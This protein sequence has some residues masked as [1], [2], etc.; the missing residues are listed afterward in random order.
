MKILLAIMM[1]II[2]FTI[3]CEKSLD[4]L[5]SSKNKT[6]ERTNERTECNSCNILFIGSSYLNYF[7]HD[8]IDIFERMTVL[9]G[10]NIYLGRKDASGWSLKKHVENQQTIELVNERN[11]D[12]VILQSGALYLSKEKWHDYI[13]P[14]IKEFRKVI[15]NNYKK[16]CVVYMLPWAY[17]DGLTW[18]EGEGDT[19]EEMQINLYNETTKLVKDIDIATAPV[20]WAWHEAISDGFEEDLYI[21]DKNH[22]SSYGAYLA[23]CVFYSTIFLEKAP[24]VYMDWSEDIDPEYFHNIADSMVNE[25]LELWNIY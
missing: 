21:L 9:A 8:V 20:G 25:N 17:K 11:W 7:G 19:Y 22:Q 2:F 6:V 24:I 15:K 10:K 3:S 23:A 4:S 16:T 12:Y 13:I 14:H 5:Q 1:I 18:M